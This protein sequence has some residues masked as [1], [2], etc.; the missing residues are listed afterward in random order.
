M[1]EYIAEI[2]GNN[3]LKNIEMAIAGEEATGAEFLRSRIS[4]HSGAD[5]NLAT[6]NNLPPGQRPTSRLIL[7]KQGDTT[8]TG[9]TTVWAGVMLV[10]GTN[11]AVIAYR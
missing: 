1:S 2:K 3:S 11:T 10:S 9:K 4:P 8:P 6:F 5:T 7:V